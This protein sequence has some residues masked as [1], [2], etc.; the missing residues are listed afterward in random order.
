M[1][2]NIFHVYLH[3]LFEFVP[4]IEKQVALVPSLGDNMAG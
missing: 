1:T 4:S 3:V 2:P